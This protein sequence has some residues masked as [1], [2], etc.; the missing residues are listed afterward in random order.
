[1]RT[2]RI[3]GV[4]VS[5]DVKNA[6]L[7]SLAKSGRAAGLDCDIVAEKRYVPCDVAVVWGQQKV[8]GRSGTKASGEHLFRSEVLTRHAGPVVIIDAPLLGRK[9]P[10]HRRRPWLFRKLVPRHAAWAHRLFPSWQPA[11]EAFSEFRIGVGGALGDNGG[12]ALAPFAHDR[13]WLLEKR[14]DLPPLKS[15]RTSGK[16]IIVIGQVPGDASLRGIDVNQW[17]L[18]TCSRL[19]QLTDRPIRVRPHPGAGDSNPE[20]VEALTGT[21]V[22]IED[23]SKPFNESLDDA[24]AVVT[25]CSGAAIDALMAGVPAIAASSASFAWDVTDHDLEHV[26]APTEFPREP[27][28]DRLAAAQWSRA[29]IDSGAIWQPLMMACDAAGL[30]RTAA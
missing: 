24:W 27:W 13:Y 1:M 26:V 15:Y 3:F 4:S 29:E 14:L 18:A 30:T 19:L 17:I 25:F 16:H 5:S 8:T 11:N 9:V 6:V 20:L 2:V 23:A 28:L 12:L 22:V 21:G 10:M 7:S